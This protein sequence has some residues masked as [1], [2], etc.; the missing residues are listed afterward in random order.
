M[1]LAKRHP[2]RQSHIYPL[3]IFLP[4]YRLPSWDGCWG[5]AQKIFAWMQEYGAEFVIAA[6]HFEHLVEE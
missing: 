6:K 3:R 2:R 4:N 5:D 1:F